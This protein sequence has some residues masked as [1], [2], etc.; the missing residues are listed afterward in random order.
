M[1]G[2]SGVGSASCPPQAGPTGTPAGPGG[3]RAEGGGPRRRRR[4]IAP[5]CRPSPSSVDCRLPTGRSPSSS[6]SSS[7]SPPSSSSPS[8]AR[9]GTRDD[10]DQYRLSSCYYNEKNGLL[11]LFWAV[12]LAIAR[13]AGATLIKKP[14]R[15]DVHLDVPEVGTKRFQVFGVRIRSLLATRS[16]GR[17]RHK[18]T[19]CFASFR[20]EAPPNRSGASVE[21]IFGDDGWTKIVISRH[22]FFPR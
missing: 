3:E 4:P 19:Y 22:L 13:P 10:E 15:H 6:S 14:L 9:R 18:E 17:N 20:S 7:S 12:L 16:C 2:G 21:K 1:M 11:S 8:R 5:R